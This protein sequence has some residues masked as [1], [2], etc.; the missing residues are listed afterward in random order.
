MSCSKRKRLEPGLMPALDRYD[1]VHFR[2]VR[3]SLRELHLGALDV[4]ILSARFGLL[5]AT[6]PIPCYE[7]PMTTGRARQLRSSVGHRIDQQ[8]RERAYGR[9]FVNLGREYLSAVASSEEL[10]RVGEAA[11]FAA[12]RIGERMAQ[13]K[14]WLLDLHATNFGTA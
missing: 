11:V 7:E 10:P 8:L 1:G 2:V 9:I 6:S 14:S 4:L 3:K 13:L 5:E 12:G